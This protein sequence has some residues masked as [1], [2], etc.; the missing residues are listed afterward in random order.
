[1][2]ENADESSSALS[3]KVTLTLVN[4]PFATQAVSPGTRE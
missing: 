3:F 2:S 1:M 4:R